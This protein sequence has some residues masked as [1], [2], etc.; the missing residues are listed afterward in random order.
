MNA[1]GTQ[2]C[3]H[4]KETHIII[5]NLTKYKSYYPIML[6]IGTIELVHTNKR[7]FALSRFIKSN[8]NC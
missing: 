3:V 1:Q 2:N 5:A 7:I 4:S 8:P 6:P